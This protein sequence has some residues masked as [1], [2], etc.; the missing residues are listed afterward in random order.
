[1]A[2]CRDVAARGTLGRMAG[3]NETSAASHFGR[4]MRKE[5]LAHGWSLPELSGRMGVNAGHLR[6]IENGK[7]PPTEALALACDE[8][9]PERRG[10]S[11][12][13]AARGKLRRA[14]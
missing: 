6:R 4:Q 9:F 14:P 10:W 11:A 1:M 13:L 5:R 2:V 8:V 3:T 12:R 7:R